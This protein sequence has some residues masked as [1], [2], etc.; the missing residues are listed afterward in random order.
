M[1]FSQ[2]LDAQIELGNIDGF[3]IETRDRTELQNELWSDYLQFCSEF[4]LIP[5]DNPEYWA[6]V[7][8]DIDNDPDLEDH[9]HDPFS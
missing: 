6:A 2:W 7:A 1:P 9:H 3:D 5:D 8:R 4:D